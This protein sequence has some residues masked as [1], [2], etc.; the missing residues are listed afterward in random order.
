MGQENVGNPKWTRFTQ[1]A[2]QDFMRIN[3]IFG[4]CGFSHMGGGGGKGIFVMP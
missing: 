3:F 4:V 1:V 2:N